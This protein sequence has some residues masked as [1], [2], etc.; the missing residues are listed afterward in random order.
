MQDSD[1]PAVMAYAERITHPRHA[2]PMEKTSKE[3]SRHQCDGCEAKEI[4]SFY[5]CVPCDFDLCLGMYHDDD[6]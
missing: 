4:K 1:A 3:V 5:R 2:H 6:L